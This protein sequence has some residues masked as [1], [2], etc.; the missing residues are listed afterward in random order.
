MKRETRDYIEYTTTKIDDSRLDYFKNNI[1]RNNITI[2]D[3]WIAK[4]GTLLY[5]YLY[6]KDS[7]AENVAQF[8]KHLTSFAEGPEGTCQ[9]N[10]SHPSLVIFAATRFN[11]NCWFGSL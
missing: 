9:T 5:N 6:A 3:K 11:S 2:D 1:F 4:F 10:A 7:T 8:K